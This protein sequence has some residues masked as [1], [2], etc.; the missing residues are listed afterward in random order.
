MIIIMFTG[1]I[2]EIGT[3]KSRK[4]AHDKAD[5]EFIIDCNYPPASLSI[6]A[7][8]SCDGICLTVT[9]AEAR[10][11]ESWFA[12]ETSPETLAVTTANTWQ[13]GR[14][15]NLEQSLRLGDD[16]GGHMVSGHVDGVVEIVDIRADAGSQCFT[17]AL[18]PQFMPFIVPKGSV[19]LNGTSFTVNETTYADK[20][21][22][23]VNIIAHT[24]AV[25]NWGT[26]QIGDKVNFEIDMFARYVAHFA[27]QTI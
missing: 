16:L 22:F 10:K 11:N 4:Q 15:L 5:I 2:T 19:T 17:F 26:A 21:I 9:K 14:K 8:I 23:N 24:L 6:G 12:V 18:P 1:I 27:K 25:T 13:A 20:A 7:S 3:I